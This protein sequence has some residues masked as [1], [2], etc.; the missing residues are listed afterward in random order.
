MS[1]IKNRNYLQASRKKTVLTQADMVALTGVCDQPHISKIE[2]GNVNPTIHTL[3]TYHLVFEKPIE[4][5]I[6]ME[7]DEVKNKLKKRLEFHV[8]QLSEE[9]PF[10][11]N[12]KRIQSLQDLLTRLK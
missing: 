3:I 10:M 7:I 12:A 4:Y 2:K 11:S 1:T 9:L 8:N 6:S 5:L